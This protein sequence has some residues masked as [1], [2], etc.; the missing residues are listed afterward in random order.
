MSR[1][2]W[3]GI[4]RIQLPGNGRRNQQDEELIEEIREVAGLV[5]RTGQEK[6]FHPM[7]PYERRLVHLTVREYDG[8]R[9][10][11][12]GDGFLK[13]VVVSSASDEPGSEPDT[14]DE[15]RPES[16]ED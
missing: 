8:L 16:G 1:R 6:K 10:R 7:N 15:S 4:G 5:A 9:S 11:S 12:V 14:A 13:T 2:A 3:P